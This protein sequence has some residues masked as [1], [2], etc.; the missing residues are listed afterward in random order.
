MYESDGWDYELQLAARRDDSVVGRLLEGAYDM[1]LHFAP[2]AWMTRRFDALDTALHAR[3]SGLAGFVLKNRTYCTQPLALLVRRL[4]PEVR[5]FGCLVLDGE[6]GGLNYHAVKAAA[7]IGTKV[8]YMP[9]F[10]AANSMPVVKRVFDLKIGGDP[11]RI[12]DDSGRLVPVVEDILR[13]VK[14]YDMVLC[15]G[16]VSPREV[17]ALADR[18]V[19]MGINKVVITHPMSEF[20]CE[21]FLSF[22]DLVMLAREGITVEHCAQA[23]SPTSERRDPALFVEAIRAQGAENCIMTTDFGGIPHPTIAE[24]LRMFISTLL[25]RGLT[26]SELELMVKANPRRLLG[27]T[28]ED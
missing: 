19:G 17:K 28:D 11:I 27:I 22:E 15:T 21:E 23:I 8:L 14:D 1:H 16:H 7:E 5:V 10:Y 4:V 6:V 24:G 3:E 9:V 12:V 20:V 13:V 18:C 25:R 26:E 2:E